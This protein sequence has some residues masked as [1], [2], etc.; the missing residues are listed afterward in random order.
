MPVLSDAVSGPGTC[1]NR[2]TFYLSCIFA[3]HTE[4]SFFSAAQHTCCFHDNHDRCRTLLLLTRA[5]TCRSFR[6]HFGI[7]D[8]A[9]LSLRHYALASS[10]FSAFLSDSCTMRRAKRFTKLFSFNDLHSRHDVFGTER[11]NPSLWSGFRCFIVMFR[12]TT[13]RNAHT[14][15]RTPVRS[16]VVK[17]HNTVGQPSSHDAA[18]VTRNETETTTYVP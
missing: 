7:I 16:N 8:R 17:R 12:Y 6:E 3:A 13:Y 11:G 4:G 9:G 1:A 18:L 2:Y 5:N 15:T 14:N 10:Q